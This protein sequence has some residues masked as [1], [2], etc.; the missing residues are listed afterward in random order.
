L[1]FKFFRALG[2]VTSQLGSNRVEDRVGDA[3]LES[4]DLVGEFRKGLH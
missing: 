1:A 3:S 2:L 4:S